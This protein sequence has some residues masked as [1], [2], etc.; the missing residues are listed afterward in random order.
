MMDDTYYI[1][2]PCGT[3]LARMGKLILFPCV[4]YFERE[5]EIEREGVS[6]REIGRER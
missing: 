1:I 5:R 2:L 4:D 6:G 3:M